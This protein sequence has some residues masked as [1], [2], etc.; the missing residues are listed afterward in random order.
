MT[1]ISHSSSFSDAKAYLSQPNVSKEL[2]FLYILQKHYPRSTVT[3]TP[4]ATNFRSFAEAGQAQATLDTTSGA[5]AAW[6]VYAPPT[7]RSSA[8]P[9]KFSDERVQF[10]KYDYTWNE[11][12]FIIYEATFMNEYHRFESESTFYFIIY[13]T[14]DPPWQNGRPKAVDDLIAAATQYSSDVHNE[15]LVFDQEAW[16]KNRD[17][18]NSVQG[19]FWDDV[20]LDDSLKSSLVTEVE[21]FFDSRADYEKFAVP[22]KV[23]RRSFI[24]PDRSLHTLVRGH[25]AHS[26]YLL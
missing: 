2:A 7:G 3:V 23:L 9:G 16:S 8:E 1:S 12:S 5:F 24:T 13:E 17:L 19:S 11:L 22:W 10:G 21:S 6:R 26:F 4:E 18:W 20:I 14:D 25:S 15:I